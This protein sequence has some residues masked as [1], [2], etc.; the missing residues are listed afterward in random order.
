MSR[1]SRNRQSTRSGVNEV[2]T[3]HQ[4]PPSPT[5]LSQAQQT[6]VRDALRELR[7]KFPNQTELARALNVKQQSISR[8]LSPTGPIGIKLASAVARVRGQAL[9]DLLQGKRPPRQF[10]ETPGWN[11]AALLV[12]REHRATPG[13]I[14]AV[15]RWPAFFEHGGEADS[16]LGEPVD[17][18]GLVTRASRRR[19]QPRRSAPKQDPGSAGGPW[20]TEIRRSFLTAADPTMV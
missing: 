3:V 13:A 10:N 14:A 15:G 4:V 9:E 17:W 8:A 12:L 5:A 20:A 2:P 6:R 7:K 16:R 11:E 19:A 1:A 18:L